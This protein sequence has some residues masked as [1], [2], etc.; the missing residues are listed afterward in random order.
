MT[1]TSLSTQEFSLNLDTALYAADNGPVF[2]TDCGTPTH[3]LLSYRHYQDLLAQHRSIA[4]S[5][6]MPGQADV[7]FN[8]PR[9]NIHL[10]KAD[11]S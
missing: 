6:A 4:A 9:C 11:F 1:I 10:R 8:A 7:E 2:V 5:L 3:V